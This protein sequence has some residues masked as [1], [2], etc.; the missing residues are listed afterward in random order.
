MV[1][2]R[3]R[4]AVIM[5]TRR[6]LN[7]GLGA[8]LAAATMMPPTHAARKHAVPWPQ[9]LTRRF[10]EIE[11]RCGGRLGVGVLDTRSGHTAGHR[12]DERFPMCSTHKALSAAAVLARVDRG[13]ERLDR[14]VRFAAEEVLP[15]SPGTEPHAGDEGMTL[16]AI[17]EAA[18]TLSD[19]TA[20]T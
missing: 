1:P 4:K 17:C 14:R 6:Q 20:A 18:I 13:K 10:A 19:N 3:A 5:V 12:A 7:L 8:T 9:E 2:P 15:Y 11:A 16:A